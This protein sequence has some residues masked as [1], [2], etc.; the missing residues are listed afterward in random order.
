[1]TSGDR[2]TWPG[3]QVDGRRHRER[4]GVAAEAIRLDPDQIASLDEA[5]APGTVAGPR[6]PDWM[7]A[8]IDR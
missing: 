6:Y 8:T 3:G 2:G 4:Q 1:M 5:L 7:M